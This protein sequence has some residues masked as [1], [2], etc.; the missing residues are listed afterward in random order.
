MLLHIF[1]IRLGQKVNLHVNLIGGRGGGSCTE[2]TMA[3]LMLRQEVQSS[4]MVTP[5]GLLTLLDFKN[6]FLSRLRA[7]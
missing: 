3:I 4:S 2:K 6:V 5:S 7:S 1:L